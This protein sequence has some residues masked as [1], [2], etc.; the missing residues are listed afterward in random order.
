MSTPTCGRF[1]VFFALGLL[2]ALGGC[3][4]GEPAPERRDA[5]GPKRP[6]PTPIA[7]HEDF[8][9]GRIGA[10]LRVGTL[11][12]GAAK[13]AAGLDNK[14]GGAG[15]GRRHGGGGISMNGIGGGG[16]GGMGGG[17]GGR[18]RREAG[19]ESSGVER[20]E[21]V[22]Q[23]L[24]GMGPAEMI[25]LQFT[26]HGTGRVELNIVDFVSPLGNFA[27]QPGKLILEP[28]QTLEVEPMTSRLGGSVTEVEATLVLHVPGRTEKKTI[29]LRAVPGGTPEP[30]PP[31]TP[32]K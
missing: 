28:G 12:L 13:E 8:F 19:G 29:V 31:A 16:G 25:H 32:G 11:D 20:P 26:N 5:T 23:I 7:G 3:A 2:L 17:G 9:D 27:V 15:G 1:P 30:A 4:S 22:R 18:Y 10:D 21:G 24:G 14:N 6:P